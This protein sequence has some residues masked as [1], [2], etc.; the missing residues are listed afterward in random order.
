[1]AKVPLTTLLA[2]RRNMG[3]YSKQNLIA[4]FSGESAACLHVMLDKV[5]LHL[6]AS[7]FT[8]VTIL[9]GNCPSRPQQKQAV[10]V[11]AHGNVEVCCS[12][13]LRSFLQG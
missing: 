11:L 3:L 1:M 10:D 7:M 6:L 13:L 9:E 5:S 4:E 2:N 12:N 8:T